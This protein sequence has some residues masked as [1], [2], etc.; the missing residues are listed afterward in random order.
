MDLSMEA[1]EAGGSVIEEDEAENGHEDELLEQRH[2][3]GLTDLG[4]APPLV[5]VPYDEVVFN[6]AINRTRAWSYQQKISD[7]RNFLKKPENFKLTIFFRKVR[8]I[9]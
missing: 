1:E 3:R 8:K 5:D 6:G 4:N 7:L 2:G 9:I